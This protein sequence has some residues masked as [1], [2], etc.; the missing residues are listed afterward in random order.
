VHFVP[1]CGKWFLVA[2]HEAKA[3][4]CGAAN[5]AFADL[6]TSQQALCH[7]TFRGGV[8]FTAPEFRRF[9]DG[10]DPP[11]SLFTGGLP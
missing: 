8:Y 4:G 1:F 7:K 3:C 2:R 11:K 9:S 6:L 5:Q 10:F